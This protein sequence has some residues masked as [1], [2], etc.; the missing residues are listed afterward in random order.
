MQQHNLASREAERSPPHNAPATVAEHPRGNAYLCK[1]ALGRHH[2][3]A[4]LKCCCFLPYC[5]IPLLQATPA[6]QPDELD[7][8]MLDEDGAPPEYLLAEMALAVEDEEDEEFDD[9]G[10]VVHYVTD[11]GQLVRVGCRDRMHTSLIVIRGARLH[12][13]EPRL[14]G[15]LAGWHARWLC[16]GCSQQQS[17]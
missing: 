15:W 11:E 4:V 8:F 9:G 3:Q 16:C 12:S 10:A 17:S 6:P 13:Q 1:T 5:E 7:E 2:L 14:A